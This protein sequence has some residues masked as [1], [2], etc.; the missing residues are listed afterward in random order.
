MFSFSAAGDNTSPLIVYPNKRLTKEIV[1]SVHG[2]WGVGM[3]DT[4]WMKREIFYEYIGNVFHPSLKKQNIEFSVI[5]S[6]DG[7]QTH[8]DRNFSDLCTELEVIL[9]A[10]YP[11]AIRILQPCDLSTFKPLKGGWRKGV[12]EWRRH[13]PTEDITKERFAPILKCVIDVMFPWNV[14]A[15]DFGK[16]L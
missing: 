5:L 4:G 8:L 2:D 3:S 10:L 6:L 7:H 11:N 1:E 15:T 12:I 13:H 9:V 16:K 14:E